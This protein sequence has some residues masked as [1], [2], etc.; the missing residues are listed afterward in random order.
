MTR[1]TVLQPEADVP[2]DRFS[3]WLDAELEFVELW[4]QSVPPLEQCG[5]GIVVLGGR[6]DALD[7]CANPWLANVKELL[8]EAHAA[9]HPVLGI[10]L[11]HQMIADAFGGTV[12][13]AAGLEGP[14]AG[15]EEGAFEVT[16]T[17]AAL[18]DPIFAKA[19]QERVS[20]VPESHNDVVTELPPGAVLLVSSKKY[21]IQGFRLGSLACV[22]FHPEASPETL[23]FWTDGHGG[24]GAAIRAELEAVD[25]KVRRLGES[26]ARGFVAALSRQELV[27]GPCALHDLPKT[28][29][30]PP[31]E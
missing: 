27:L 21:E 20:V 12:T 25:D 18:R 5:D 14:L 31:T 11:G 29:W 19:A 23:Q 7:H 10:C 26:I 22:Q 28:V 13:L 30:S 15:G 9:G 8:V 4:H 6:M 16:W 17:E 2:L 24:D 3:Q 1:I